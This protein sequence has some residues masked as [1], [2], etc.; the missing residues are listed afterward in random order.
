MLVGKDSET[1]FYTLFFKISTY[2]IGYLRP[3][4]I[5]MCKHIGT[6]SMETAHGWYVKQMNAHMTLDIV[7][8]ALNAVYLRGK[9][10]MHDSQ[11]FNLT[12]A[13]VSTYW[14]VLM[15]SCISSTSFNVLTLAGQGWTHPF[16]VS[17]CRW[18]R[19]TWLVTAN[20]PSP[21]SKLTARHFTWRKASRCSSQMFT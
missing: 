7:Y 12:N 20:G 1:E 8:S 11:Y 18:R 6:G 14:I 17:E 13:V 10:D 15:K 19:E 4:S 21:C 3:V 9:L 2:I 5:Q 16:V